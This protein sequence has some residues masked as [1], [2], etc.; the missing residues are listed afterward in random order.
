MII[1]RKERITV[2]LVGRPKDP[3]WDQAV[4]DATAVMTEVQEEGLEE[5]SFPEKFLSHRRGEFVAFPVGVSFGGG[6]TV[7][8]YLK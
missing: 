6:Q 2:A 3:T 4:H 5:D 8:L 7:R 1:D